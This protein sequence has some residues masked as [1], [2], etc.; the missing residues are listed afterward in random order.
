MRGYTSKTKIEN[1]TLQTIN[2]SFDSQITAWIESVERYIEQLTGRIFIADL[3]ASEKKYDGEGETSQKFDEFV[4]LTKLELGE[5]DPALSP[6]TINRVEV[7]NTDYRLYPNNQEN[8]ATIMLRSG[9]FP[10]GYQNV[11]VTARWGYSDT[12]PAD[13]ELAATIL[14][15]GITNYSNNAKGKVRSESLGR[16]SVS[17]ETDKG[18]S[19][20]E[21]AKSIL[22]SYK[23]FTF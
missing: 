8:K 14:V 3:V 15:A 2:A 11:V 19:D 4:Q 5:D 7:P 9:Y 1:Y 17:Y 16:Y 18:W 10:C 21:R 22:D 12:L 13:I 6:S 20:Y 23:R